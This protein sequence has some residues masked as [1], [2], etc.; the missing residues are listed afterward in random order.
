MTGLDGPAMRL[1]QQ[2]VALL[3]QGRLAQA[4][5]LL[6][7]VLARCPASPDAHQLL[8]TVLAALGRPGEAE[9][10]LRQ[11]VQARPE[12]ADAHGN[13]G[14]LL[15]DL[16][17]PGDAVAC[18]RRAIQLRP[19]YPE[20]HNNLGAALR[21]LGHHAAAGASFREALRQRPGFALCHANLGGLLRH[22]GDMPA[23]EAQFRAAL[24]AGDATAEVLAGLGA[25]LRGQGRD[26]DA[27]APLR[28]ALR[29]EPERT[30]CWVELGLA[31]IG[32]HRAAEAVPCFE[33]AL[34]LAPGLAEARL[35]LGVAMAA[36]G[37]YDRAERQVREAVAL[38]PS[39]AAAHNALGDILRNRA[40]FA[41]SEASLRHALALA[42]DLAEAQVNLAFTLLQTGRMAEGWAAYEHRWRAAPWVHRPRALPGRPWRGEPLAG[43]SIL[44]HGEQG[45]GDSLQ[46]L[47]F[48]TLFAPDTRVVLQVQQPLVGL[49]RCLPGHVTVLGPEDAP[50]PVDWHCALLSLPHRFGGRPVPAPP[51][52]SADPAAV[53]EWRRRLAAAPGLRV[54]L[55]WAGSPGL[56]ANARRSLPLRDLDALAGLAGVSFVSLQRG[57]AAAE[58]SALP[59]WRPQMR[60]DGFDDTAALVAAL[61]LVIS[62][63]SSVLH[64][65]GA[66]GGPVWLLN[67]HDPCWR[68]QHGEAGS[69]W[70]PSLRQFRQTVPGHW[71]NVVQQVRQALQERCPQ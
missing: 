55:A 9:P 28:Q 30:E 1:L 32:C 52:L 71:G 8:G 39:L 4:E 40:E 13:L 26:R 59:L 27:E 43:Q 10:L 35:G 47:R 14:N 49:L 54:G 18:L 67:R 7:A 64:L 2:G 53:A 24:G 5:P 20:A 15:R 41:A 17:R 61:D 60:G 37:E 12:S 63:D 16:G 25:S 44:L 29:H 23:A 6:R 42:P 58:P 3:Q 21:D 38:A 57:P 65:A 31:L 19:H 69:A 70:Y 22:Q 36:Q 45:L 51:Y 33:A 62:V 34:R 46:F 11:A 66:L 50:P 68:W 48:V 56:V